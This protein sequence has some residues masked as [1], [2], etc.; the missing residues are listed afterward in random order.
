MPALPKIFQSDARCRPPTEKNVVDVPESVSVPHD[1][2]HVPAVCST[3]SDRAA[4]ESPRGR[5]PTASAD[6]LRRD[7]GGDGDAEA[8]G[9]AAT[10][11]SRSFC[12]DMFFQPQLVRHA[13]LI[14]EQLTNRSFQRLNPRRLFSMQAFSS[15]ERPVSLA[16][17]GCAAAIPD[18]ISGSSD[19]RFILV[20]QI[21][22]RRLD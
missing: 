20:A 8:A 18:P 22:Q 4:R 11:L 17:F 12:P 7:G 1:T 16:P 6:A 3:E 10:V 14:L 5:G 21:H 15:D 13:M 9:A 19:D 2:R